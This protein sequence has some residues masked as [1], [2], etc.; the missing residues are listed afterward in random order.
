[1]IDLKL[2]GVPDSL[3]LLKIALY[4]S[5]LCGLKKYDSSVEAIIDPETD[6]SGWHRPLRTSSSAL[7]LTILATLDNL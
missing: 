5:L 6:L 4:I 3:V 7:T 1:M 2:G